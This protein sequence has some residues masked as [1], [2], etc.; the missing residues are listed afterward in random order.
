MGNDHS[1]D[2]DTPGRKHPPEGATYEIGYCK[3]PASTQFKP[4]QIGNPKGRKKKQKLDLRREIVE[5]GEEVAE[6]VS[7]LERA[8]RGEVNEAAKGSTKHARLVFNRALKHRFV[9]KYIAPGNIEWMDTPGE[10]GDILR[11]YRHERE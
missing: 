9:E 6:G 7:M 2:D 1:Q 3:P 4:G 10:W 8:I 5:A 11:T